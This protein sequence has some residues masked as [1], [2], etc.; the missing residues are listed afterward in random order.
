MVCG[1]ILGELVVKILKPDREL[2]DCLLGFLTNGKKLSEQFSLWN[3]VMKKLKEFS[4]NVLER[5]ALP[6]VEVRI[7][8]SGRSIEGECEFRDF[9]RLDLCSSQPLR[10]VVGLPCR[11]ESTYV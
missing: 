8:A 1:D 5:C 9:G 2:G 7:P 10:R 4:A 6:R 3:F 11:H